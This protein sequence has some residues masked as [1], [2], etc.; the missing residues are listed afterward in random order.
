MNFFI[1]I[2]D[3]KA[4]ST[5]LCLNC[6]DDAAIKF[7]CNKAQ[8]PLLNLP[9]GDIWCLIWRTISKEKSVEMRDFT[10]EIIE[11]IDGGY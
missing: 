7:E 1:E 9:R 8:I 3:I 4:H 10:N 11:E 2:G 5:Y 6:K